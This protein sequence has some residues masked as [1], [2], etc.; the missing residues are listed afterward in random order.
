MVLI[1]RMIITLFLRKNNAVID[2]SFKYRYHLMQSPA[3]LTNVD[4]VLC[5]SID[6]KA[7]LSQVQTK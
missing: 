3:I 6:D 4:A 7:I 1:I 5:I 2:D